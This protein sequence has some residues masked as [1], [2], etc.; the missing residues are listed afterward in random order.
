LLSCIWFFRAQGLDLDRLSCLGFL[1][2]WF[3]GRKFYVVLVAILLY[4]ADAICAFSG[5][6]YFDFGTAIRYLK[7][8]RQVSLWLVAPLA[9][10]LVAAT[11]LSPG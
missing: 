5:I 9:L 1:V 2:C 4:C 11:A 10:A 7:D 6:Y 8:L 3:R